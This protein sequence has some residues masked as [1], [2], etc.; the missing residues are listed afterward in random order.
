MP[1]TLSAKPGA[2]RTRKSRER[3]MRG[4]LLVQ[5]EVVRTSLIDRGRLILDG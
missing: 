4:G 1:Y 2:K 5:F 3:Q